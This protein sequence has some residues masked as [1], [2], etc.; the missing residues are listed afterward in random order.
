MAFTKAQLDAYIQGLY[1]DDGQLSEADNQ[2]IINYIL[3]NGNPELNP[4]DLI[5]IRRGDEADLPTLA[6]GEQAITLDTEVYVIGGLNGNIK[7]PTRNTPIP[8]PNTDVAT[9]N[10]L[11]LLMSGK[12][13]AFINGET[14]NLDDTLIF[15]NQCDIVI[16]TNTILDFN[17]SAKDC[18]RLTG[19]NINVYGG[20]K[21]KMPEA[22]DGTNTQWLYAAIHIY[23]DE[24][25]VKEIRLENV[26]KVGIG[27]E[28]S[29]CVV[30]DNVI[31]GNYPSAQFTGVE[32]AHFGVAVSPKGFDIDGAIVNNNSIK[33]CVTGVFVGTYGGGETYG[34]NIV[35]NMLEKCY[36]HGVYANGGQGNIISNNNIFDC[37]GAIAT[38]GKHCLVLG[39]NIFNPNVGGVFDKTSISVREASKCIIKGNIIKGEGLTSGTVIDLIT[40]VG[41]PLPNTILDNN[42]V[43]GNIIDIPLGNVQAI[44]V[45][46]SSQTE[47]SY[48]NIIRGNIINANGITGLIAIF[49]KAGFVGKNNQVVGNQINVKNNVPAIYPYN[50]KQMIISDNS[51][52]FEYNA[53]VA[54]TITLINSLALTKSVIANNLI[55]CDATFGANVTLRG[56][57]EDASCGFNLV[58]GNNIYLDP[59]LLVAK[60]EV[61]LNATSVAVNNLLTGVLT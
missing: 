45:G 43:E 61:F 30:I 4:R 56:Y 47:V 24:C 9:I 11:I 16:P 49:T 33:N 48:N 18:L 60:T 40:L 12:D 38:Y 35:S 55:M 13:F 51:I 50:Q 17:V 36:D 8:I 52:T 29:K 32:T 53:S 15:P 26:Q 59:T 28:G 27:I 3:S 58:Q 44:R 41:D 14:Y 5:Q 1:D 46:S 7:I 42:I 21:I 57:R 10:S 34:L 22:W 25:S 2:L 54:E 31:N 20:G 39:N 37:K 6:Q 23:G 19:D